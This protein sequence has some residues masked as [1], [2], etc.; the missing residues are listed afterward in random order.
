MPYGVPMTLQ[1]FAI[2][3]AGA[4]LGM[5]NG[6]LAALIYVM[7]GAAGAPV[8]AGFTGGLAVIFGRT[9]GFIL[10]FPLLALTAAVG[11]KHKKTMWFVLWLVTGA[12][13]LY[14]S[15]MFMFS[16]VTS[17]SLKAA[18]ALVV[19]PF[20][21]TEIVKIAMVVSLSKMIKNALKMRGVD[22]L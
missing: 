11:A 5:K 1:T 2:P 3:L 6:T 7:L 13:I 20:I 21:P 4:V 17:N 18:F 10:A 8:F 14:T 22:L 12:I 9:G 15:G 19:A 16:L